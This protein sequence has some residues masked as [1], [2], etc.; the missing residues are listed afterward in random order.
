MIHIHLL[1]DHK[2]RP[3]L[4]SGAFT[5]V[6]EKCENMSCSFEIEFLVLGVPVAVTYRLNW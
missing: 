1:S 2:E 5:P 3:I 4:I 6:Y